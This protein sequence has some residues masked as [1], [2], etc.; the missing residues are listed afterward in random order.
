MSGNLLDVNFLIALLWKNHVQHG[1]ARAWLS[2]HKTES[3]VTCHLTENGL[4]RL[5]MNPQV[6]GETV[7]FA[8]ACAVLEQLR[9]HPK[10]VFWPMEVDFLSLTHGIPVSGYRQVTDALLLG[11]AKARKGRLVTFDTKM[12]DL[13]RNTHRME[14]HLVIA[15]F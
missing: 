11:L 13:V 10:H 6:V 12:A 5:S 15:E 8:G 7:A 2:A 3:F 4:I 14:R 9:N 1:A